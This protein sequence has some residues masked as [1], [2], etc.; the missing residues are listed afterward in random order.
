MIN[1][2][3]PTLVAFLIA[4]TM[5]LTEAVFNLSHTPGMGSQSTT[6]RSMAMWWLD[7]IRRKRETSAPTQFAFS[8]FHSCKSV[9]DP[10]HIQ[11]GLPSRKMLPQSCPEVCLLHDSE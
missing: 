4:L 6:Q 3:R 7:C 11:G 5:Y 1:T 8:L 10:A 2:R 9:E